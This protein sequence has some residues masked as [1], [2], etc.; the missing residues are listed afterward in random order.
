[1]LL[2]LF[3]LYLQGLV[4]AL[5]LVLVICLLWIFLRA[6]SRKDK[7]VVERQAFLY[8]ILMIAILLVPILSFA[9]MS[10]LLA[11]KS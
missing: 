3:S 4:I 10:I 8:D 5:I 11:L 6:R 7:T 9:V 1:M 2:E